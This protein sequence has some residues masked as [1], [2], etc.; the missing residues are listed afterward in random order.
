MRHG[1]QGT[2]CGPTSVP[3][4]DL[5]VCF[6]SCP[7]SAPAFFGV[8]GGTSS[9]PAT[10]MATGV[11][12]HVEGV[13]A[14]YG[15][16]P[17]TGPGVRL[18]PRAASCMVGVRIP[19]CLMT[20]TDTIAALALAV[21]MV[22]AVAA[23]GSWKAARDSHDAAAPLSRIEQQPASPSPKPTLRTDHPPVRLQQPANLRPSA[24]TTVRCP[25]RRGH[26]RSLAHGR[27]RTEP[28][29]PGSQ[30]A[31]VRRRQYDPSAAGDHIQADRLTLVDNP[32]TRSFA[33]SRTPP[34]RQ[35]AARS[36]KLKPLSQAFHIVIRSGSHGN[37]L[38][39]RRWR[40]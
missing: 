8:H 38:V 16:T 21:A 5:R 14:R 35:L 20:T 28:R 15:C 12:V 30:T 39:S 4:A 6:R 11:G 31:Q 26:R 17:T 9:L 2:A 7:R 18:A 37:A 40:S 10:A 33:C 32:S 24:A 27:S 22:A 25:R 1:R 29:T 19:S 23:V 36:L 13:L 3:E 34:A